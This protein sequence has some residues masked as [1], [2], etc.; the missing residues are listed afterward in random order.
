MGNK[1]DFIEAVRYMLD[2]KLCED[3][4]GR[5]Y[6]I[7]NRKFYY[8]E[9]GNRILCFNYEIPTATEWKLIK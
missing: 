8:K 2:G 4:N 7:K 5:I 9:Y 6:K 1:I 3:F